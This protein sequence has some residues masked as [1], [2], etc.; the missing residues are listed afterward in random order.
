M[1]KDFVFTLKLTALQIQ[2]LAVALQKAPLP[3]ELTG[4][5]FAT[6]QQQVSE[7]EAGQAKLNTI[8]QKKK[9]TKRTR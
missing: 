7:A 2:T 6:I 8:I 3:L 4:P 9:P 5:L 1:D